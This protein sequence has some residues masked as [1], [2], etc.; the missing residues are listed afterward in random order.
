MPTYEKTHRYCSFCQ[1][2]T[3][4]YRQG[5]N[6]VLHLLLTVLMC[7]WWLPV[8]ILLSI[9][10]GGWRCEACGAIKTG[11]ALATGLAVFCV[12]AFLLFVLS[13]PT[14]LSVL[15]FRPPPAGP[16]NEV[17]G[18]TDEEPARERRE[19]ASQDARKPDIAEPPD[20]RAF[21]RLLPD[22]A[23]SARESGMVAEV[24]LDHAPR[25]WT[26]SSGKFAVEAAF[27]K[28]AMDKVTIRRLD[29]GKEITVSL[30]TLSDEDRKFVDSLKR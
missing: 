13:G 27:V 17:A 1:R 9:N 15:P 6:H 3:P 5:T 16:P 10:I 20:S 30:D 19:Q 18:E 8:W 14:Q 25:I 28:R 4:H 2:T 21:P 26:D 11:N 12:T 29:N 24:D 23:V 22:D 7:G